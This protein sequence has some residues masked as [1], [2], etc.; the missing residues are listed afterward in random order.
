MEMISANNLDI[1]SCKFRKVRNSY[2][3]NVFLLL[4]IPVIIFFLISMIYF[5][6][7]KKIFHE[8]ILSAKDNPILYVISFAISFSSFLGLR[9]FYSLGECF[10]DSLFQGKKSTDE[11]KSKMLKKFIE[12]GN[13][14][15]ASDFFK[16]IDS[17]LE[18]NDKNRQQAV[19]NQL[20]FKFFPEKLLNGQIEYPMAVPPNGLEKTIIKNCGYFTGFNGIYIV[21]RLWADP[22]FFSEEK[23]PYIQAY[24]ISMS[25]IERYFAVERGKIAPGN[26]LLVEYQRYYWGCDVSIKNDTNNAVYCGD[27]DYLKIRIRSLKRKNVECETEC[28][29]RLRIVDEVGNHWVWNGS[30]HNENNWD[31]FINNE[32]QK[33][34][35]GSIAYKNANSDSSRI[36]LNFSEDFK[37]FYFR[38]DN[39]KLWRPFVKDGCGAPLATPKEDSRINYIQLVVL[40]FGLPPDLQNTNN[41]SLFPQQDRELG[42]SKGKPS[43]TLVSPIK[44]A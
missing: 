20:D 14:V 7:E 16:K 4:S 32:T 13:T 34:K 25:D 39:L 3:G 2:L 42:M 6:I 38:I 27:K 36:E 19:K 44:F 21:Q 8:Y 15:C 9:K 41:E 17:N 31:T 43:F 40:E 18:L 29:F 10:V 5:L 35:Y 28:S 1:S 24:R 12:L 22:R 37:D 30:P 33:I 26:Y 11:D 23:K